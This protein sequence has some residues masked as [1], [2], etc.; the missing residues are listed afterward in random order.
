MWIYQRNCRE[1]DRI[2]YYQDRNEWH[3]IDYDGKL[4]SLIM[5]MTMIWWWKYRSGKYY[6]YVMFNETKDWAMAITIII[7]WWL[8]DFFLSLEWVRDDD[9]ME[10]I[11]YYNQDLNEISKYMDVCGCMSESS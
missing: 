3:A 7:M 11:S 9:W 1:M 6:Y 2:L 4:T 8:K 5:W 10:W